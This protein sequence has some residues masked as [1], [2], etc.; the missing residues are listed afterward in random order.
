MQPRSILHTTS[1]IFSSADRR[2]VEKALGRISF[3][4]RG[5]ANYGFSLLIRWSARPPTKRYL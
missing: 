5:G 1:T 2:M 3:P 4:W